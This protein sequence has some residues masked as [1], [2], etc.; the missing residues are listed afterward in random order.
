MIFEA[1]SPQ[2]S[3]LNLHCKRFRIGAGDS[4][5]CHAA[6][7]PV[8]ASMKSSIDIEHWGYDAVRPLPSIR[9]SIVEDL[10]RQNQRA[11]YFRSINCR[12]FN[13]Q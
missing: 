8:S 2:H 6:T 11:S 5:W 12:W 9:K 3:E 13:G 7:L 10:A 1:A 4:W